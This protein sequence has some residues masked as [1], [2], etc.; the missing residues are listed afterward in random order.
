MLCYQSYPCPLSSCTWA[1]DFYFAIP[2]S[3]FSRFFPD[4]KLKKK[5]PYLY[6][7]FFFFQRTCYQVVT[8]S[9][10]M[11]ILTNYD[12]T[13]DV[14]SDAGGEAETWG[15][16]AGYGII[17]AEQIL[18]WIALN[19]RESCPGERQ[20]LWEPWQA[21][22]FLGFWIRVHRQHANGPNLNLFT[23]WYNKMTRVG[24][25]QMRSSF[26]RVGTQ[27]ALSSSTICNTPTLF[28]S[29]VLFALCN[30]CTR[31]CYIADTRTFTR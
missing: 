9:D 3:P 23:F 15:T 1:T 30:R 24:I 11:E 22:H 29:L 10:M 7:M 12:Y 28:S 2:Y 26:L 8:Y 20:I 31:K 25:V 5:T 16:E 21:E 13:I 27:L 14:T 19:C 18:G 17:S 6:Y 4:E